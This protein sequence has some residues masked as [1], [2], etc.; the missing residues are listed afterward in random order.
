MEKK[1]RR[2][3]AFRRPIPLILLLRKL[4]V[5][6][7]I[8]KQMGRNKMTPKIEEICDQFAVEMRAQGIPEMPATI[9]ANT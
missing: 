7:T 9:T 5:Q 4:E 2:W 3:K 6:S 8:N 1:A